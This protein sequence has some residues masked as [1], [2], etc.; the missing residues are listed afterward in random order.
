MK[1]PLP[2]LGRS[3]AALPQ[4]QIDGVEIGG[5]QAA[6]SRQAPIRARASERFRDREA[7]P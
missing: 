3:F 7:E 2:R 6:L 5:R 1:L 4:T